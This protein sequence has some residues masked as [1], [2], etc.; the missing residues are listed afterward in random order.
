[1]IVLVCGPPAVGKTTI[2]TRARE[3]LAAAGIPFRLLHSDDFSRRT[4][5]RLYAAV[6]EAPE[7]D[8]IVDGTFYR[9]EWRE[10]F[11]EL[12]DV[13]LV[14][15]TA[16]LETCLARNRAREEPIDERGVH[17]IYREFDPVDADLT[18]N[19]DRATVEAATEQVVAAIERWRSA[20]RTEV[21]SGWGGRNAGRR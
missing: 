13:R 2:A 16:P 1:V 20:G 18:V 6:A 15:L 19:T 12:G 21:N 9:E 8:W 7:E 11:R 5:D 3:R 4:Y 17:V 14:H 10:R